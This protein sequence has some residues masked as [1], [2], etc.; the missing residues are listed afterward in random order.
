MFSRSSF[1]ILWLLIL[2]IFIRRMAYAKR[3]SKMPRNFEM[4]EKNQK[5]QKKLAD[6]LK[7]FLDT[8]T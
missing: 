1:F 6:F 2:V 3:G 7:K 4:V 8:A 5:L